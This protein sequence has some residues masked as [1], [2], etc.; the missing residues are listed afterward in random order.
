MNDSTN[1]ASR[2]TALLALAAAGSL[3]G[4]GFVFGKVALPALGVEH[5]LFYRFLFA[6]LALVPVVIQKRIGLPR[7]E[8]ILRIFVSGAL[9]VPIQFV[10]QFEG[11]SRTTVSHASLMVGAL[12]VLLAVAATV[13]GE[14][15]LDRIGWLTLL[16]STAGAALIVSGGS[17][18]GQSSVRGDL[19][20]VA[21]LFAAVGWVL[22]SK[23]LM[24]KD[25]GYEPVAASVYVL[26]AGT[27]LLMA[28]VL[29]VAGPPSVHLAPRV[30]GAV[31][32][33]GVVATA[34][35]TLLWNWGLTRVPASR[36][37]IFLNLEPVVGVILGVALLHDHLGPLTILGGALIVGTA[38]VFTRRPETDS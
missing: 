22:S 16:A 28:Y 13:F 7:R 8:D 6:V 14:E 26:F 19:L 35:T 11:L 38:I 10:V 37:G 33:S 32:A 9:Y 21:S 24:R 27:A 31:I 2:R 3:W 5:M 4:T 17:T 12:P 25:G 30:W 29:V 36:A 15:K 23:R 34:A 20:V 18:K 1:P